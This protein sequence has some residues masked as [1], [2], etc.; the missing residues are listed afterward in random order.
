MSCG[1]A[2]RSV[3]RRM[4]VPRISHA[5]WLLGRG[6]LYQVADFSGSCVGW[7]ELLWNVVSTG[8]LGFVVAGLH[9]RGGAGGCVAGAAVERREYR[10]AGFRR[11]GLSLAGVSRV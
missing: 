9:W 5:G 11:R 2:V 8:G 7:G 6:G 1:Y 4:A 3:G 10:R